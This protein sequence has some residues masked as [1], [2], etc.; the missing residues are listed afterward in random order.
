MKRSAFASPRT[1]GRMAELEN[2]SPVD[3][4]IIEM[5]L[6]QMREVEKEVGG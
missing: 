1:R 4:Q 5:R 2:L 3:R 6:R